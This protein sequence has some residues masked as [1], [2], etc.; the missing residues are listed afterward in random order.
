MARLEQQI[1]RFEP[2]PYQPAPSEAVVIGRRPEG[3]E[4]A[5]LRFVEKHH[6]E[7]EVR[8]MRRGVVPQHR[9]A[10]ALQSQRRRNRESRAGTRGGRPRL[11]HLG[12]PRPR[13]LHAAFHHGTRA[14]G[15]PAPLLRLRVRGDG[16]R[17]RGDARGGGTR[18]PAARGTLRALRRQENRLPQ[19]EH[20]LY[21]H[22]IPPVLAQGTDGRALHGRIRPRARGNQQP[23]GGTEPGRPHRPLAQRR[24]QPLGV[25]RGYGQRLLRP[26]VGVVV[27]A[28]AEPSPA[29]PR[30]QRVARRGGVLQQRSPGPLLARSGAAIRAVLRHARQRHHPHPRA[31]RT[32]LR[33][34][35]RPRHEEPA[36][37]PRTCGTA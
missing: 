1:A 31:G 35:G 36:L 27:A 11:S 33:L 29:A 18:N 3:R 9:R 5:R 19:Q 10:P 24:I 4:Y 28:V 22:G 8:K 17:G 16:R 14:P 32:A 12:R 25:P 26:D 37:R 13:R 34:T 21:R 15:R 20:F 30:G 6:A 7:P 23:H 2:P